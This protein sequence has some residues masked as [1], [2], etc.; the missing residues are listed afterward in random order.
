MYS[1]L[2]KVVENSDPPSKL[3]CY[4]LLTNQNHFNV[5]INRKTWTVHCLLD[6]FYHEFDEKF[7]KKKTSFWGLPW[8]ESQ[9]FFWKFSSVAPINKSTIRIKPENVLNPTKNCCVCRR[10]IFFQKLHQAFFDLKILLFI[11]CTPNCTLLHS[12]MLTIDSNFVKTPG[13]E[14]FALLTPPTTRQLG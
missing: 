13:W 1:F 9:Q 6:T 8:G 2:T 14:F 10:L 11:R 3:T 4:L 5:T 7:L 12:C